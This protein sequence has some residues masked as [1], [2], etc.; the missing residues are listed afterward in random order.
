MKYLSLFSWVGGFECAIHQ[1]FPDAE[2]MG[3]SEIDPYAISRYQE[4][5][6][7]H[8]NFWDVSSIDISALPDF[9]LLV[10]GSPCQDLS[11]AKNNRKG[12]EGERSWLFWKYVDI[13]KAKKPKWFILENVNSMPQEVKRIITETLGVE[14]IMI[15]ASLVSAQRRKRLF[16]TNIPWVIQPEDRG[17]LLSDILEYGCTDKEKSLCVTANY[18][19]MNK[20]N[21]Q[22]WQGQM[23][24]IRQ[25][26]RWFNKGGDHFEKSPTVTSNSRQQNNKLRI[27][28]ELRKLTPLEVER[29][30]CFP[31]NW[32][33]W[34]SASRRYKALGNAVNVEVVKH[35]LSFLK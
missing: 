34:L 6:P 33:L 10:G 20:Q 27:D 24:F 29:L 16:R 9:D 19:K 30:Q 26:A 5:F 23:V 1:L 14:P 4:H 3:Y 32:T 17:I 22:R 13:L 7:T 21:Y 8:H 25:A 28:W 35:I 2:C 18:W 12:L 31:D 11:I 15:D